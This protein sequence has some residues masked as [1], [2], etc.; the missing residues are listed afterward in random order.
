MRDTSRLKSTAAI[1]PSTRDALIAG[2]QAVLA[3]EGPSAPISEITDRAGVAIGSFYNHFESKEELFRLAARSGLAEWEDYMIRR[4]ADLDD[5]EERLC[6]RIRLMGRMSDIRPDI[7]HIIVNS[8]PRL[9]AMPTGY[10]E[11]AVPDLQGARDGDDAGAS[12]SGLRFMVVVAAG[13]K[14]LAL[15]LQDPTIPAER[16]DEL[17]ETLMIFLGTDPAE[18]RRLSRLP[19]PPE[20]AT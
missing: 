15:R 4:T 8:G 12:N 16:A 1:R 19:L 7:A 6:A 2:A 10:S 5:Q 14:L 11:R 17:A 20:P 18:A 3:E 9:L 13:E